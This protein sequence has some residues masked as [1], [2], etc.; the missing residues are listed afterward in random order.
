MLASSI[1]QGSSAGW[2][3]GFCA[4]C[5]VI[6]FVDLL[7]SLVVLCHGLAFDIQ[8][9][10]NGTGL[11]NGRWGKYFDFAHCY[12]ARRFAYRC[13]TSQAVI[14]GDEGGISPA[15]ASFIAQTVQA[16]LAAGRS[17]HSSPPVLTTPPQ[18]MAVEVPN[19]LGPVSMASSCSG[20]VLS[21]L[22]SS[23][24]N[25]LEAGTGLLQ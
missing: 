16:A 21:S 18:S 10:A 17:A 24:S 7:D 2:P 14:S 19:S 12:I 4:A 8:Y 11:S 25:F 9:F 1:F 6:L 22:G 20:G 3:G 5:T 15:L 13:M 23:A